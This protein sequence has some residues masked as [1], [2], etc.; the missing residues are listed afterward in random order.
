[1]ENDAV[2]ESVFKAVLFDLDGTLTNPCIGITNSVI[3]ALE[4][5]EY[6]VPPREELRCF[7][8]PPL[9]ESFRKY[10]GMDEQTAVEGVRLYREYFA[11]R[12]IFENKLMDGAE[13]L[14]CELRRRGT[15]IFLATSKPREFTER[16][17]SH[18]GISEYFDYVGAATMDGRIGEKH[19]VILDVLENTGANPNE[20]LMVGD[21]LH[22]IVGAHKFGIKCCAVL[23]GFGSPEEFDEYGADFVCERLCEVADLV[24]KQTS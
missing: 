13:E 17:I 4:R 12:G 15:R 8:G 1:M 19:E 23:C 20:C 6:E 24:E 5:L 18:F 9:A 2:S 7:I 3:Y 16:I 21:R 10:F 22:D 11:D 14:L